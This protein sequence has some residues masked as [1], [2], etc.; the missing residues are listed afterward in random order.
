MT[1]VVSDVCVCT[2]RTP[3]QKLTDASMPVNHALLTLHNARGMSDG[4][5]VNLGQIRNLGSR[6]LN[7]F[8]RIPR[9]HGSET[10]V[11]FAS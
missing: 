9:R 5:D 11:A 6:G 7:V 1:E 3:G 2:T 10:A 4:L 8:G